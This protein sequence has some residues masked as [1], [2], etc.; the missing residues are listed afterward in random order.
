MSKT[1]LAKILSLLFFVLISTPLFAQEIT[2]TWHGV[3]KVQGTQLR[4]VFHISKTPTGFSTTMDSPDQG[5]KGIATQETSFEQGV[6]KISAPAMGLEYTGKL[7]SDQTI[8][9]DFKQGGQ[10]FPLPL[11]RAVIGNEKPVRPQTPSTP[12]PYYTEDIT[13]ENKVAN[14]SLAGTLSLPKKE[15]NYPVVILI[16]GSGPQNRNSDL[17]GHQPFLVLADFLTKNGIAVLTYDDRG[18]AKSGGDFSKATT[19]DFASDVESAFAYLKTRKEIN[20]K[21]I[22]LIGHSE[23]GLIAPMVAAKQKDLAFIVLLAGPGMPTSQL[24]L[25]QKEKI[26]RQ[27]GASATEIARGQEIFKGAYQLI[28]AANDNDAALK[29]KL[30]TY[31]KAK[32]GAEASDQDLSKLINQ[33]TS[34]WMFNFLKI[35]P[36]D[37]LKNV[38]CPVLALNGELDLQVP[39]KENLQA[40]KLI[41]NNSGNKKLTVKE[42][43][44]VNHLFQECETGAIDEYSKIEQTLS[45]TVLT[46]I[47]NWLRL[48]TK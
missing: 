11:S 5:A 14:I 24:M 47:L 46:E 28:L 48:Q 34:T 44:K 32:G 13:F 35:N 4:V 26:E 2:G 18:V 9:G 15:G 22:G 16:S 29:E 6:L 20:A 23:G 3:L 1:K 45:P 31:F 10:S 36:A 7:N 40:I 8:S 25:L 38:H 30:T 27:L 43:P 41:L 19:Q 12:Y 37:F 42:F 21:K 33:I 17:F 39:P